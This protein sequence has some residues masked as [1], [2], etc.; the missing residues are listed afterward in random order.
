MTTAN[1]LADVLLDLVEAQLGALAR[2]PLPRFE[3]P[4][5][6]LGHEV[7][8]DVRADLLFT[9]GL[10]HE[11]GRKEVDGIEVADAISSL[12]A[13]VHGRRT[14]TFY[15]YRVAETVARYGR[16]DAANPVLAPLDDAQREQVAVAVDSTEWLELLDAGILPRNYAAVLARCEHARHRLGLLHDTTVLDELLGRVTAMLGGH[17]DDSNARIGRYDIYTVDIHL[18][19]EPLAAQ[20]G[21]RKSVV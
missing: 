4:G 5:A 1:D 20:L 15:S 13:G 11:A 9:L 2:G 8:A 7:G 6:L 21:D 18:F 12:L 17:L 14:H 10:L 16:F 3:L 19:C